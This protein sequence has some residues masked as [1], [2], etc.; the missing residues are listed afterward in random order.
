MMFDHR[1]EIEAHG[2]GLDGDLGFFREEFRIRNAV[3]ILK[4][5]MDTYLH[6]I[7]TPSDSIAGGS[8]HIALG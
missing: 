5:E 8:G 1:R 6:D 4:T 3:Q 2:F 7:R